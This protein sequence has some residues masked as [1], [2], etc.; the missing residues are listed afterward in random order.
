MERIILLEMRLG[1][2]CF[3]SFFCS[4]D[5][6]MFRKE[7]IVATGKDA[8]RGCAF[9]GPMTVEIRCYGK[10]FHLS[11]NDAEC[12]FFCHQRED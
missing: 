11:R 8:G 5:M 9:L 7:S 6:Q 12:S 1:M 3:L 2:L 4:L 10:A